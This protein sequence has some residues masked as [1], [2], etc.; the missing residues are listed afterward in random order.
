MNEKELI[1]IFNILN[2]VSIVLSCIVLIFLYRNAKWNSYFSAL[3]VNFHISL[4][5]D[6]IVCVPYLYRS[7]Y[8]LCIAVEVF[9]TYLD[10]FN[11]SVLLV[12][13]MCHCLLIVGKYGIV[14][15][16]LTGLR[17]FIY[18]YP[19]IITF[20][21]FVTY[22]YEIS[23]NN[24]W[25]SIPHLK[26]RWPVFLYYITVWLFLAIAVIMVTYTAIKLCRSQHAAEKLFTVFFSTVGLYAFFGFCLWVPRSVFRFDHDEENHDDNNYQ[27]FLS[28]FIS[29]IPIA[30]EG[31]VF[32]C[33]FFFQER[34]AIISFETDLSNSTAGAQSIFTW[35]KGEDVLRLIS[36]E[37]NSSSSSTTNHS[38][39]IDHF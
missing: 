6:G 33:I 31:F 35:E 24:P 21:P 28:Y 1:L 13:V 19:L 17:I 27:I 15:K 30:V 20:L 14:V 25:C 39:H 3:L 29:Y 34:V 12:L 9:R 22:S 11:I 5:L 23:N 37:Y 4:V 26:N 38:F 18:V 7:N 32:F 10:M 2:S 8:D 16:V 36:D